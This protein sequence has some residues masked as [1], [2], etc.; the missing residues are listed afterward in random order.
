MA[1]FA[2]Y[3]QFVRAFELGQSSFST[4]RKVS[5]QSTALGVWYD[6][7]MSSGYPKAQYYAATPLEATALS[8]T[9][10]GG[11]YH[12]GAVSPKTKYLHR[13]MGLGVGGPVPYVGILCDYLMYYSFVDEGTTD[14]Q[15]TVNGITLPRYT[16]GAGVQIMAVSLGTRT[17]GQSVTV[18]YTNSDGV[19]GR[20]TPAHVQNAGSAYGQLPLTER[21]GS[22]AHGPFMTLQGTDTGVRSV[23]AVKMAGVDTGLFAVVLVKPIAQFSQFESTAPVEI[24][25]L[26]DFSHL[27]VIKDDAFL[28]ILACAVAT[29]NGGNCQGVIETVWN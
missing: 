14:Q 26:K 28:S 13:L 29:W 24:D 17:G 20:V 8:Q 5:N 4:F 2:N 19:A 9:E 25:Y 6:L 12:G 27:P 15:D 1:G 21:V 23:E 16:D 10:N 11:I 22:S 18:T 7:S 3:G